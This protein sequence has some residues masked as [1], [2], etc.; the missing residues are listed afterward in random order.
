MF[1]LPT[2]KQL[3]LIL[4]AWVSAIHLMAANAQAVAATWPQW[5]GPDRDGLVSG[6]A[7]PEKLDTNHLREV[8]RVELGPSYSGPIVSSDR[9]FATQT[10]DKKFEVV[11]AHDRS[12]GKELW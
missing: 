2:M 9:V 10:K 5:R 12:S 1:G 4:A 7:W 6:P 8:W 11:T 3:P